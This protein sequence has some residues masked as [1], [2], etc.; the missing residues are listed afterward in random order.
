LIHLLSQLIERSA[1]RVAEQA[2]FRCPPNAIT[3][4]ELARTCNQLANFLGEEGVRRGD[5]VGILL[6]RCLESATAVHGI[7]KAGT[8]FVPIDPATP[9]AR[10]RRIIEDAGI[11]HLITNGRQRGSVEELLRAPSTIESILGVDHLETHVRLHAWESLAGFSSR[12]PNTSI[13]EQDLAYIMFTSGSTGR[14]KGIA[15]THFSGLSYAELSAATYDVNSNDCIGNPSSLHFDMSTFGYFTGPWAGATTVIVPDAYLKLPASLS[16]MMQAERMTIWYSV[17][18]ALTQLLLRGACEQRDLSSLRWVL[19]G[20]EPIPAKHLHALMLAWPHARFSNVYGPAEV[21][22]CTYYHVPPITEDAAADDAKPIPIG[23][24]WNRTEGLVLV[25]G[26]PARIG[27]AGELLIRSPTMMRGYWARPDLDAAAF[28]RREVG[29]NFSDV[30]YRTGDLVRL[31]PDGNYAFLGRQD[32]QIKLRGHRVEMDDIEVTISAHP[33]V[34][35]VGAYPV[36]RH[37]EV[38]EIAATVLLREPRVN[39]TR[40]EDIAAFAAKHLPAYAVPT[41]LSFT[42]ALPRTTSGKIDR[43]SLQALAQQS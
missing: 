16:A 23:K 34:E 28:Y 39:P 21:N 42:D 19:F 22:Q 9:I 10:M 43:R 38:V 37:G 7:L 20:G 26:R 32:R 36:I 14:P 25:D 33:D 24:V 27:E 8:A 31:D 1:D 41:Q 29:P 15:H 6:P 17:P 18:F 35:E 11:R 12:S 40:L 13:H 2:A 4:A 5:R 30:F 3:Y